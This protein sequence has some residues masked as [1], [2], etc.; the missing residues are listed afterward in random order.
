MKEKYE[1]KLY[2]KIEF[3]HEKSR[4]DHNSLIIFSDIITKF[5]N[6]ITDFSKSLESITTRKSKIIV[7]KETSIYKLTH[8]FKLNL[9][10]HI[11]ESKECAYHLSSNILG[12]I[13]QSI[14]E[15]YSKE[16]DLYTNYNKIK[17][18]Y[19]NAKT[20]LEKSR[21]EFETNAKLCEKSILHF[22]QLK[23]YDINNSNDYLKFEEK[24]KF[25]ISHAKNYE[26]KYFQS[27]EEANKL[28]EKEIKAQKELL[29]YYQ[30]NDLDFFSKVNC[31]ISYFMPIL[32]KMYSTILK[33]LE[34]VEDQCKKVNIK[35]DINLLIERYKSNEMPEEP[36][37]FIPYN[38]EASLE[39]PTTTGNDRK[40]LENLDINYN[41]VLILYEN[42]RDIKKDTEME[43]EKRKYRLRYLC[44]KIFKIG[45]G[46]DF[47][48]EE[49]NELLSFLNEQA[50]KSYFLITLS[51]Q[52]TK[53]R[54]RRSLSLLKDLSEILNYILD[55]AKKTDDYESAKNCIILSQTFYSE[56]QKGKEMKKKYL[57][58]YIKDNNWLNSID[59]WKK[60]I[61][62]MIELEIIKNE[63]I[64]KN[65]NM[66]ESTE[67]RKI[68]IDNIIF[69]QILSYTNIMIEFSLDKEEIIK[70]ADFYIKKH[71]IEKS[72]KDVLIENIKN[73]PYPSKEEDNEEDFEFEIKTRPKSKSMLRKTKNE[74][75][76]YSTKNFRKYDDID[77]N[78]EKLREGKNK[79]IEKDKIIKE[80]E[81]INILKEEDKNIQD[82]KID[83]NENI[84]YNKDDKENKEDKEDKNENN[85]DKNNENDNQI[86]EENKK[87]KKENNIIENEKESINKNDEK[88]E[89]IKNINEI[90]GI[91]GNSSEN[92]NKI[93]DEEQTKGRL[94]GYIRKEEL[95]LD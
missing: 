87:N 43:E 42:F 58:D 5:I 80:E 6:S 88:N 45:P 19:I 54:Y 2:G 3:L 53:G 7:E 10:A 49:K 61:E 15:K 91:I 72:L 90:E 67:Q 93:K 50:F 92:I 8:L 29:N 38:P 34:G 27:L 1:D 81:E 20:S 76:R 71:N 33:S 4:R 56:R 13:I 85:K 41:I 86:K 22:L 12:P 84:I 59:F 89:E 78:M 14:D 31:M 70:I 77:K 55:G 25:S 79:I 48:Q 62:K 57:F 36:I 46:I 26:D 66:K 63:K 9:K 51:K 95:L 82:K 83:K 24:M 74:L 73:T 68:R 23:S 40:D 52:R 30:E 21:K 11:H 94:T 60:L 32:K 18:S 16:K 39:M 75:A 37:K 17:N 35:E 69:S 28:R 44:S 47:K 65:E 64:G